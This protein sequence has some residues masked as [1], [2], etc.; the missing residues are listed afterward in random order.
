M[1]IVAG[2]SAAEMRP[3]KVCRRHQRIGGTGKAAG[4]LALAGKG[5]D[6]A[7]AGEI[8]RVYTYIY[9]SMPS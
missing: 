2:L 3:A 5:A 6:D 4:L 9:W 8:F 1:T 7:R